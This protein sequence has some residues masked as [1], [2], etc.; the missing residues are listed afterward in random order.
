M[1]GSILENF[2]LII[3]KKIEEANK[4]YKNIDFDIDLDGDEGDEVQ[5]G[6]ILDMAYA[7]NDRVNK[8]IEALTYALEKV[9]AGEYGVCEECGEDIGIKRLE[10]IPDAKFCIRCTEE[11]EKELKQKRI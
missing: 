11:F 4:T 2:K 10:A 9:E 6:I 5:G 7:H 8:S 3:L 1:E